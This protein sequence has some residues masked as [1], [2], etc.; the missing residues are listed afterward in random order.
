DNDF[1]LGAGGELLQLGHDIE[2][3]RS[4]NREHCHDEDQLLYAATTNRILLT[5][6]RRDL[7]LLHDAWHRWGRAWSVQHQHAGILV[8]PQGRTYRE[9]VT[10]VLAL[11][12]QNE[13]VTNQ[14][15]ICGGS[16]D[17]R[18]YPDP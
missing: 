16:G 7:R 8:L 5:H 9:H 1:P 15:H 11:L 2:S 14:L 17:W 13:S 18:R 3:A 4:T 6:N 10:R 12:G